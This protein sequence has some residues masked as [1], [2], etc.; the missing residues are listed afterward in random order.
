MSAATTIAP[1]RIPAL[2]LLTPEQLAEL[3]T[4]V[5]WKG[6]ALIAHAWAVIFGSMAL[7]AMFPNPLTYILAVM[8]IGSRQLGLA[9][10]MHD[11]AHGCLSRNEARNIAFSQWLCAF[12][13]FADTLAY[14]GYHL[15]HHA[16][17]Q[18]EDDPDLVLSAPFPI[19]KASYR[20]KFF[21]DITGQTGYQQRKAQFL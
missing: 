9:I 13:V 7:V 20:R 1:R 4:R 3:R 11:G 8:L 17:T 12:P 19:T 14:R 18:R 2:A 16:H 21:R 6:M 10:L 5:E 15:A